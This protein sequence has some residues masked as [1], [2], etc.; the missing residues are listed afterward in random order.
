[1]S[2]VA[3][4]RSTPSSLLSF[5]ALAFSVGAVVAWVLAGIVDDGLY[6]VSGALGIVGFGLGAKARR[7]V[8]R[9]GSSGRL[10]LTAMIVGGLLGAAVI[11]A[12]VVWGFSHLV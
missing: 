7:E 9:A 8:R 6:A 12:T 10:A 11:V 4:V 1:M 2:E 5:V 3:S